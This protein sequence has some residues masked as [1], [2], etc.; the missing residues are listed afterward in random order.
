MSNSAR[1]LLRGVVVVLCA[2]SLVSAAAPALAADEEGCLG[3]HGL[4]GLAV[5]AGGV[6]RDLGIAGRGFE[7]SMHRDLGCRECHADIVSIPHAESREPGC[8]QPCHGRTAG[9]KE[10]SHEGLYWEYTASVHGSS[11]VRKI[12]CLMCHPSPERRETL[13]RDK[14]AESRQCAACHRESHL[15]REWFT[16]RHFLA[17]AGGNP[18][19]PSCPD[20]HSAHR[21]RPA[22]S[23]ESTVNRKRLADTCANGALGP[24]RRGAC[25]AALGESAVAGATMNPLPKRRLGQEPPLLVLTL[26]AGALMAGLVVRAGV[27]LAR[28]R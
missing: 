14:L 2:A 22:S 12:G 23:P 26:L 11:R 7:A 9:G 21:V 15:V 13:E 3:C 10:Y 1:V 6:R 16:D 17:L 27:G 8:G 4:R 28:G 24:E 18:R 25:H 5:R 19:A 20:C